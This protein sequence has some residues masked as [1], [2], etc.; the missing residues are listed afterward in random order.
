MRAFPFLALILLAGCQ[1]AA[2][3]PAATHA[4]AQPA[5]QVLAKDAEIP[6]ANHGGIYDWRAEGRDAIL[7]ESI[8][9]HFYR[10]TFMAP[11]ED[12][13]FVERVGFVTDAR[14]TL[15]KFESIVVRHQECVFAS[16]T[17]IPKP[18]HW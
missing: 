8:D 9:H 11:C 13:P 15:D 14:D 7:I 4:T 17:E 16:F 1:A 18:E 6:F 3:P 12:L 2:P 5:P 10:A